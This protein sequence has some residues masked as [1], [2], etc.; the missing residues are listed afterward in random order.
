M[1]PQGQF[2]LNFIKYFMK[3]T[4]GTVKVALGQFPLV[5]QGFR[6]E[7]YRKP[8]RSLHNNFES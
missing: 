4:E 7:I 1:S 5:T 6:K 2:P 3:K 8:P